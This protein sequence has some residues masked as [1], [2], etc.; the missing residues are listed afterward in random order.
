[1]RGVLLVGL[2]LSPNVSWAIE[3]CT[4]MYPKVAQIEERLVCLQ[5]NQDELLSRLEKLETTRPNDPNVI[6]A[7]DFVVIG[8]ETANGGGPGCLS[9]GRGTDFPEPARFANCYRGGPM[10]YKIDK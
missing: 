10:K 7:G 1:M 4:E 9:G 6:R 5:K 3:D 8:H 2:L